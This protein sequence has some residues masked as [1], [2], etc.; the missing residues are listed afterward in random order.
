M[1]ITKWNHNAIITSTRVKKAAVALKQGTWFIVIWTLLRVKT[2][3]MHRILSS[4]VRPS[5]PNSIIRWL[6]V[7]YRILQRNFSVI[8]T[9]SIKRCSNSLTL[10]LVC[11]QQ[12]TRNS[13]LWRQETRLS[14]PKKHSTSPCYTNLWKRRG[15]VLQ[16]QEA[17]ARPNRMTSLGRVSPTKEV[18]LAAI[19][20]AL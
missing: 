9:N 10:A 13:K 7:K 5:K 4:E 15:Q 3:W 11:P 14:S 2:L 1:I 20:L 17:W 19:R 16:K 18:Q 6:R 12:Y 8:L